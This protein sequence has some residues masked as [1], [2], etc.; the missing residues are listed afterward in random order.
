MASTKAKR[1]K[2]SK[3]TDPTRNA[4]QARRVAALQA[5]AQRDG[6][7]TLSGALTAWMYG[8]AVLVRALDA[9]TEPEASEAKHE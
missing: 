1:I 7:D 2:P 6:F 8:R 3:P 4:R 5:A 9:A